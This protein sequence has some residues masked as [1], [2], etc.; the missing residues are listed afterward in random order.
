MKLNL[1]QKKILKLLAINCRFTIRDIAKSIGVS[2]DAVRYQ[3]NNL[4]NK[5][6]LGFFNVQFVHPNLNYKSAHHWVKL[7]VDFPLEKLKQI[8]HINSINSSYGKFNYQLL[9]FTKTK[10]QLIETKRAIKKLKP[11]IYKSAELVGQFKRFTNLVPPIDVRVKIPSNRKKA[12][13]FLNEEQYGEPNLDYKIKLDKKDKKIIFSLLKNPRATFQHI[14]QETEI[15]HET[16]K[17]RIKRY[18]QNHFIN[19][20]GL[21]PNLN[22]YG[23]YNA[24]LLFKLK[25]LNE[26]ELSIYLN[27]KKNIY[28]SPKFEGDYGGMIY[29]LS[30]TPDELGKIY[31]EISLL[32][33]K[34]LI[35]L[36]MIFWGEVHKYIQFPVEELI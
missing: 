4:V 27:S 11:L 31:N 16:V 2:K 10:K 13:Y 9:S 30:K 21:V 12:E 5:R 15:N 17:Y 35:E 33:D 23:L 25:H 22:K 14:S 24:Y 3:I 29:I 20:F 28:Y 6:K 7:P 19:N 18:V 1:K 26:K 34:N 32:L 8:P 36:D